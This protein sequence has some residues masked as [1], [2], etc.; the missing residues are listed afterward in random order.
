MSCVCQNP[1]TFTHFVFAII[2]LGNSFSYFLEIIMLISWVGTLSQNK[3][4]S[5]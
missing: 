1:D 2:I 5:R 3:N 4:G